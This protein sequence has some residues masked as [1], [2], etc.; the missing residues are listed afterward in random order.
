MSIRRIII[1]GGSGFIGKYLVRYFSNAGYIIKVFTRCP[2]K[3]KQLRLCGLLGQI[4]I[5]SG[6]IN[7]NKEL[8]EH[9]SGCYCVINL[10][11]TLYNTKK[12]TFYN[13][14]AHVAENIAKIAKQLNVELMVHFSA[15]GIDNICNSDYAKSKLI[16]ERLVKESFP[17]AVIV[18]P[19]LVFGP[20]DKFFNKFAR[21][22]MI[23]PF[24][25]VVGGG[26]F[27]FQPVYVDDVAKLVFHIIDYRIKDKLY[28]VCG[29]S[30]YSF[31]ELL[32]LILSITHRKS[33]LF[34]IPFCLASILAFV[35]EIKMISIF[36]KLI[37]GST[38]PILTRDQVK[39]MMGMTQLH[40]MYPIDDLKEM[41]INFATV[42]D[43]VPQYLEIYKNS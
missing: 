31:K 13:V 27:V 7:N 14:H 28:N 39:F 4:E 15:M 24:L 21:L 30:T 1:F 10:I 23:L 9:I 37:T 32:N 38:D 5:V 17:D 36:S 18:R 29:P 11:G 41:G 22:L 42:E 20:E 12:T 3:A 43:I 25:P 2:E 33:K 26:K 19:N 40:D 34:N 35:F 8:V 16:G 6:D